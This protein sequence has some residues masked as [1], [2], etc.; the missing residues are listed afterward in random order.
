M[1]VDCFIFYNELDMLE[2][3]LNV[4]SPFVD[5][6]ILVESTKTFAGNDKELYYKNNLSKF[7]LYNHKIIHIIV[8]DIPDTNNAW[9]REYFQRNAIQRGID[10]LN[11]LLDDLIIISDLYEIP[12]MNTLLNNINIIKHYQLVVLRQDFYYYTL[13]YDQLKKW[14]GSKVLTYNAYNMLE[15]SSQKIREINAFPIEKG[16]WHLSYFGGPEFVKNKLQEFSHQEFNNDNFTNLEKIKNKI[17]NGENLFDNFK[18]KYVTIK[19]NSYLP[20]NI[21][22]LLRFFHAN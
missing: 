16:G 17:N 10:K 22:L 14:N 18:F 8:D 3:R 4:L 13:N 6:F 2:Y 21:E 12:D 20:P 9:N 5:Y 15:K 11:L 1:I 7:E 19:E